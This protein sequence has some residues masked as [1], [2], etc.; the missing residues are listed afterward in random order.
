MSSNDI[1]DGELSVREFVVEREGYKGYMTEYDFG[2]K[3][4][5][6]K[7]N[8]LFHYGAALSPSAA[9]RNIESMI[10][11]FLRTNAG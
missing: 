3:W 2:W 8:E 5:I 6:D 7:D 9:A 4:E 10:N 1:G 11:V